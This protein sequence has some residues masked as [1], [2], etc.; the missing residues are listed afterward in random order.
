MFTKEILTVCFNGVF[1]QTC[2][3]KPI[4]KK[5]QWYPVPKHFTQTPLKDEVFDLR[6][7][8]KEEINSEK[9]KGDVVIK[10]GCELLRTSV[11]RQSSP[12]PSFSN[13][14]DQAPL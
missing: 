3:N 14:S 12:P 2:S 6:E 7:Q 9:A 4:L 10:R 5:P 11:N 13:A 1:S 8:G